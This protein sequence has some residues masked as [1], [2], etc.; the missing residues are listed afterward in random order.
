MTLQLTIQGLTEFQGDIANAVSSELP[1][2]VK[3]AMV[4][5]VN[6]VKNSAQGMVAYKTG[7]LR[8]SIFT[9][10]SDT[11]FQGKVTQ[12]SSVAPYGIYIEYGT[13][14]HAINPV[15]AKALFWPG[16]A[17]PVKRVMHP[18]TSARPFMT[19]A[20]ENNLDTITAYFS[21]AIKNVVLR[22]AGKA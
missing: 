14:A 20:L 13:A 22:M 11:G 3:W 6:A 2:Q 21:Q 9:D 10:V 18:G 5:S 17:H 12:D 19:P 1:K 16:A 4:Q 7:T 15:N 8:R